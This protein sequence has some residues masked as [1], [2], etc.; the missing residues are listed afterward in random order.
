MIMEVKLVAPLNAVYP[1]LVKLELESNV[2][3]VKLVA[4]LN[5]WSL[6]VITF[7][8]MIILVKLSHP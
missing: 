6:M 4:S 3:E 5:A 8:G 1:M 2:T 7:D